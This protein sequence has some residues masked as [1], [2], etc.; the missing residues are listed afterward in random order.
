MPT[1]INFTTKSK[2]PANYSNLVL[3]SVGEFKDLMLSGI[4]MTGNNSQVVIS[5]ASIMM[6]IDAAI[7]Y[8]ERAFSVRLRKTI[9][10]ESR[11][12][13]YQDFATGY[14]KTSYPLAEVYKLTGNLGSSQIVEYP[15]EW[16]APRVGND[17]IYMRNLF[18]VPNGQGSIVAQTSFFM[19][20]F[21]MTLRNYVRIAN[22]WNITYATGFDKIPRDLLMLILKLAAIHTLIQIELSISSGNYSGMFGNASSSLSLDGMSQSVSKVNGGSIF[23]QRV[24]Q[25]WDEFNKMFPIMKGFYSSITFDVA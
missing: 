22:Y 3:I 6:N 16:A 25:Y 18:M 14:I 1:T 5:D 23:G 24:K 17:G 2:N 13:L 11:D 10:V 7:Q 19:N 21:Y 20:Q 15:I 9:I 4:P 12:Y 8:I